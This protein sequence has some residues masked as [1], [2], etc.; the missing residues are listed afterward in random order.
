MR[1]FAT[2][3]TTSMCSTDPVAHTSTIDMSVQL[4]MMPSALVD[5]RQHDVGESAKRRAQ[6]V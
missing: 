2:E 4:V 5:E 6:G 1:S 3:R